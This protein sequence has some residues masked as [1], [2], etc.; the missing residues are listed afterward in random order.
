MMPSLRFKH[1]ASRVDRLENVVKQIRTISAGDP[2]GKLQL[3]RLTAAWGNFGYSASLS[4]L[5]EVERLFSE[6]SGTVLECGSGVTTLLLGLLA[7]KYDRLV[8]TFENHDKWGAHIAEIAQLLQLDNLQVCQT[9]LRNYGDYD[10]YDLQE[11]HIRYGIG[12]VVCDGPP[13]TI[14]GGRYGLMP[15]M[16]QFMRPD[17]RILLD[18]THRKQEKALIRRWASERCLTWN[19]LGTT[20]RCTEIAFA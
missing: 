7:E 14:R 11:Q 18:D 12:L 8:Y 2:V 9:P 5:H 10:W 16:S 13:G 15:V 3:A 20:G 4:Y 1:T 19:P 17:C 6:S